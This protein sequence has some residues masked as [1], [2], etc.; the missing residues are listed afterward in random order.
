MSL[1]KCGKNI[2]EFSLCGQSLKGKVVEMY[3]ADT[4]KIVLPL[5][6]TLYKFT[7]RLNGIDSPEM[8][9]NK[10]KPNREIEILW[11]KKARKELLNYVCSNNL[12]F[13]N[14]D[15]K[16]EEIA[17]ELENNRNLVL[18]KCLEFDKYGRLLVELYNERDQDSANKML[19]N[20]GMAVGYNGGTKKAPWI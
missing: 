15:I 12:I 20:K 5:N 11:A 4:C 3:D 13:D 14:L 10:E 1:E 19:V 9:P 18:V 8:K 17:R 2:P 7:C 16:K 6:N